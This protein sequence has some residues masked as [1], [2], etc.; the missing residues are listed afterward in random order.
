MAISDLLTKLSTDIAS[1]YAKIQEKGGTIPTNK[2]TENLV[3]AID[4]IPSGPIPPDENTLLLLHLDSDYVDS[5]TYNRTPS[6]TNPTLNYVDGKF[7]KAL[8]GI[9]NAQ[10][11]ITYNSLYNIVENDFTIDFWFY[12]YQFASSSAGNGRPIMGCYK[13]NAW[14]VQWRVFVSE[15]QG[16]MKK[17]GFGYADGTNTFQLSS[18]TELTQGL[19]YHLAVTYDNTTKK[20]VLFV[21]GTKNAEATLNFTMTSP[22]TATR[23]TF[24]VG[25]WF[26]NYAYQPN[27]YI[28]EVRISDIV[29]YTENFTPPIEPY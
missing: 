27:G 29:R 10:G 17:W 1:A 14:E 19:W 20:M 5:S 15:Y 18:T 23:Q 22:T 3:D 16:N 24:S 25:N 4:S 8:N 12:P 2:N 13:R 21:N 7:S 11:I 28:D 9:S 6:A 26:S